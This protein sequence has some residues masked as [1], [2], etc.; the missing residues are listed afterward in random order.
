VGDRVNA[1][2]ALALFYQQT[3]SVEPFTGA[4]S[5]GDT[6]AT[7]QNVVGFYDGARKLVRD[8]DGEQVVSSSTFYTEPENAAA[9]TVN[10]R[11]TY[12]TAVSR[13]LG[14][15][16]HESGSLGLPDHIAVSLT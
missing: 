11:V 8:S 2:Q 16:Y 5:N 13:V 4:G 10:S 12:K 14:I 3:V 6:F 7:A 9:F 1:K 15:E